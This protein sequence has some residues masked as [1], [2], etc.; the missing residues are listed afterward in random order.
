MKEDLY[1]VVYHIGPQE[2]QPL[3]LPSPPLGR[4]PLLHK[5][6]VKK[7][8]APSMVVGSGAGGGPP[9]PAPRP[10]SK[11]IATS[12]DASVLKSKGES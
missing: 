3:R 11:L 2:P 7:P 1:K 6:L 12:S 10:H 5:P 4:R 9:L 8:S